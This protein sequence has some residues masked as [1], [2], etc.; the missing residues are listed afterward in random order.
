MNS[1]R[2]G[3]PTVST[4]CTS[5][6]QYLKDARTIKNNNERRY[7]SFPPPTQ[8]KKI[9]RKKEKT[10]AINETGRRRRSNLQPIDQPIAGVRS[11]FPYEDCMRHATD[12]DRVQETGTERCGGGGRSGASTSS[13]RAATG[14]ARSRR[15]GSWPR[16]SPPPRRA[17]RARP[18]PARASGRSRGR[19]RCGP[20]PP[21]RSGRR[22][23]QRPRRRG[24]PPP[25]S[26]SWP[27]ACGARG[28]AARGGTARR[29][30]ARPPAPPAPPPRRG[31]SSTPRRT[32]PPSRPPPPRTAAARAPDAARAP[33]APPRAGTA[34]AAAPTPAPPPPPPGTET[35]TPTQT[36]TL[37]PTASW[38]RSRTPKPTA[39]GCAAAASAGA[40]GAGRRARA[41]CWPR[42]PSPA[43]ARSPPPPLATSVA[44]ARRHHLEI[45]AGESERTSGRPREETHSHGGGEDERGGCGMR[46]APPYIL[47][48]FRPADGWGLP[49]HIYIQ[50][51]GLGLA[52]SGEPVRPLHGRRDPFLVVGRLARGSSYLSICSFF[53]YPSLFFLVPLF[54]AILCS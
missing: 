29:A 4:T 11:S 5:E 36:P 49:H 18:P 37:M 35:L 33:A 6:Q 34:A 26:S 38:T 41:P 3:W 2:Q 16:P 53:S 50:T 44:A 19:R 9:F 13:P 45:R 27:R 14:C 52:S 43:I 40:R 15:P 42:R 21:P 39:G 17:R 32:P 22:T 23:R 8:C 30:R 51:R 1:R 54:L 20:G 46:G 28:R 7:S 25:P 12:R 48:S 47:G 31:S 10:R 24:A